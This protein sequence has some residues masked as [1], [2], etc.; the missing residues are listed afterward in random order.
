MTD[1]RV[2]EWRLRDM[3]RRLAATPDPAEFAAMQATM[4]RYQ[5]MAE[6]AWNMAVLDHTDLVTLKQ[7]V[8]DLECDARNARLLAQTESPGARMDRAV[9]GYYWQRL[10][11]FPDEPGDAT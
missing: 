8:D 10:F 2:N 1:I 5:Q 9:A 7:R 6:Q 4:Q 3:E 11:R